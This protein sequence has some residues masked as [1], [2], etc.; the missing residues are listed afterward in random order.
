MSAKFCITCRWHT[1]IPP[2]GWEAHTGRSL[3]CT[4]DLVRHSR[5]DRVMGIPVS[6]YCVYARE[7]ELMSRALGRFTSPCG[8]DGVLWQ[9]ADYVKSA[10]TKDDSCPKMN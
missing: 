10:D 9:A 6:V 2:F 5:P 4:H 7:G 1:G 3:F 8:E